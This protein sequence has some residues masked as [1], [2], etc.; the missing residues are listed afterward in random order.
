MYNNFGKLKIRIN[1]INP[2]AIMAIAIPIT[3]S[4]K[5]LR[6]TIEKIK[7][8]VNKAIKPVILSK[9]TEAADSDCEFI[10]RPRR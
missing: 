1:V 3:G 4:R 8:N 2:I 9:N 7:A 10:C 6:L 5:I